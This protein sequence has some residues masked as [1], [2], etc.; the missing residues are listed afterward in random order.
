M[1]RLLGLSRVRFSGRVLVNVDRSEAELSAKGATA[2]ELEPLLRYRE[3]ALEGFGQRARLNAEAMLDLK[4][5]E[6]A[7]ALVGE[8]RRLEARQL[9]RSSVS[10]RASAQ[11]ALLWLAARGGFVTEALLLAKRRLKGA[12]RRQ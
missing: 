5:M 9:L 7:R 2:H 11:Y 6:R 4:A 10:G 1:L 12:A 3:Q 8:G